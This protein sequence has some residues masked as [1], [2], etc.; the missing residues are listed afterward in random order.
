MA[1]PQLIELAAASLFKDGGKRAIVR[2]DW[3]GRRLL[4]AAGATEERI[5]AARLLSNRSSGRMGVFVAQAARLR[6]A[7]VDLIHGPLQVPSAW[8]EGLNAHPITSSQDLERELIRHQP[9]A[10]A[11]AMLAA[12]AD[13]R[14][15]DG[16]WRETLQTGA[17]R[18]DAGG[19][20]GGP[21]LL[22][23]LVVRRPPGQRLLGFC[24][25]YRI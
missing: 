15:C 4:V 19:L 7:E 1:D 16:G 2:R 9:A 5:D 13:L 18:P 25:A 23:G 3:Q 14:R 6:G 20:A 21:D 8:L 22:R 12:V 11:V 17:S 10:D 24:G